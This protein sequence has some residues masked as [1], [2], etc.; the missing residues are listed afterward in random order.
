[1]KKKGISEGTDLMIDFLQPKHGKEILSLGT[2]DHN[3][4]GLSKSL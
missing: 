2:R 3:G 1:M 4:P